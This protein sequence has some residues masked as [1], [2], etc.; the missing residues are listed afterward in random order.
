MT[1]RVVVTGLGCISALG[2][3]CAEFWSALRDGRPGIG[4]LR[5]VEPGRVRFP[6]GAE[7]HDFDPALH[8]EPS[9]LDLLDRFAQFAVVTTREAVR[10]AGLVWSDMRRWLGRW[11]SVG[12]SNWP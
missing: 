4:P 10:D 7:V 2:A 5:C 6:N 8:F 12:D 3:S 11:P 1:R 9:R